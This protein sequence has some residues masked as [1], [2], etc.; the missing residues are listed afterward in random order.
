[1]MT[2]FQER[3]V[4]TQRLPLFCCFVSLILTFVFTRVH[5]RMIRAGI[6]WATC[7]STPGVGTWCSHC[8]AVSPG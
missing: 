7:I 5:V 8:S 6:G 1:M 4:D 3:V 2:W